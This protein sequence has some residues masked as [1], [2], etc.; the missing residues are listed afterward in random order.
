MHMATLFTGIHPPK[1]IHDGIREL[2]LSALMPFTFFHQTLIE[3]LSKMRQFAESGKFR[4]E[5]NKSLL[6]QN[7]QSN[8]ET[9]EKVIITLRWWLWGNGM[10]VWENS[11]RSGLGRSEEASAKE[12]F[13]RS[14]LV[15]V[16]IRCIR[17]CNK[18]PFNNKG[19][20]LTRVMSSVVQLWLCSVLSPLEGP[21]WQRSGSLISWQRKKRTWWVTCW[22]SLEGHIPLPPHFTGP[23]KSHGHSRCLKVEDI[24]SSVSENY[25][26]RAQAIL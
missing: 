1:T 14:N 7:S 20:F 10:G 25:H 13:L 17:C 19:C 5:S 11:N 2:N 15:S 26:K 18:W 4:N 23:S 24:K 9:H 22:L 6:A 12:W 8:G 21:G 3:Y 16:R